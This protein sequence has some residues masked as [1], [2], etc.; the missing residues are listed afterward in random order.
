LP[1]SLIP[2]SGCLSLCSTHCLPFQSLAC[3]INHSAQQWKQATMIPIRKSLPAKQ[4]ADLR[5]ISI[6]PV[7]TRIMEKTLVRNFLYPTL[8]SPPS[9]LSFSDQFAFCPSGSRCAAII[10]LLNT[11]TNMLLSNPS[12]TVIFL[13]FSNAFD[14]VRH[15]T[16]LKKMAQLDLQVNV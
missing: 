7:L 1:S 13:D 5:P 14:T 3:H 4:H 2:P 11:I 16:L 15:S 8:L 12:V 10:S 6:T 9:T